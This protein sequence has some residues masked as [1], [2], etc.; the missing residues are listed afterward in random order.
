EK[1]KS[2]MTPSKDD[3]RVPF[4]VSA[5]VVESLAYDLILGHD[6]M[7]H[8]GLDIRYSDDPVKITG[9]R[10]KEEAPR[11]AWFSEHPVQAS[12][13]CMKAHYYTSSSSSSAR[14]AS[15]AMAG[16]EDY[17]NDSFDL[18][19]PEYLPAS[20][21]LKVQVTPLSDEQLREKNLP[22]MSDGIP[23]VPPSAT[24]PE[25]ELVPVESW[26]PP[27]FQDV[28]D[29]EGDPL[30]D[31][32]RFAV[33]DFGDTSIRLPDFC[34]DPSAE[35]RPVATLCEEFS[36]LFA[37]RPGYCEAAEHCIN[38]GASAPQ[39][40]RVRP[41]PH[42]WR[43]E[44]TGML[45]EM[46]SLGV[47]R[48]STSPWRYPCV[49]VPKK[50]GKVRMCIDYRGLNRLCETEAY[51]V[52]RPDDVQEHLG[53]AKYFTTLDL[54]SGYWQVP[55]RPED[56]A[57]TAFCPG[58]GFP[59]YEWLRMPFGLASAPATFQRLMDSIVGDL[60]FVKCYL[61][62]LLIYSSSMEEHLDHLRQVFAIL[63]K[64]GL[65]IAAEKCAI[66]ETTVDYLGH[67]FGPDGMMPDAKKVD[68]IL[69]WPTPT[70]VTELR[71]FLGLANY[72]RG[73][74]PHYSE[75]T[76]ALYDLLTGTAK[77]KLSA[78]PPW[79]PV[80]EVAFLDVKES[81][82]RLPLLAYP[83]F[84]RPFQLV[85]D[86]SDV[87]IGSVLE[88]D[89]RPLCFFSQ[90]LTATQKRWPVYEREAFAIFRSLDR[91]RNLLLG[92]HLELIVYTDHKPLTFMA[93]STTPKVQ[94]WMLSLC[95]Y[96]FTVKYRPGKENVVADA[97]SRIPSARTVT[98]EIDGDGEAMI[99]VGPA[100][101]L[102]PCGTSTVT[103]SPDVLRWSS[104]SYGT[105]DEGLVVI[106]LTLP[107]DV[108]LREQLADP[109]L[110]LLRRKLRPD[111]W[112]PEDYLNHRLVPYRFKLSSLGLD[113]RGLLVRRL[114][115][116]PEQ[117]ATY[118]PVMPARLRPQ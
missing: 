105:I 19:C 22:V 21:G 45:Q 60:P 63:R 99:P 16:R 52:P 117:G 64:F 81:L 85:T 43:E 49:F 113:T 91:F 96:E 97:L 8:F 14:S 40:E 112:L 20:A 88:Q 23:M 48:R 58:P 87:A 36:D 24:P 98:D 90:S 32:L 115:P 95:Q 83:D 29:L 101:M 94:R 33:P 37:V 73:F 9:D 26:P 104:L 55:V 67:T 56:Q 57:K 116:L 42:R 82:A 68:A 31:P 18:S 12:N 92:Y 46:E 78:L 61:D 103:Y 4:N 10:P 86:A 27:G 3:P 54:R 38:T 114:T 111:L 11:T 75:R 65:T 77:S 108:L 107:R 72:Y 28:D 80:H 76:R 93:T 110:A 79:T 59:L 102:M 6:F 17:A 2:G 70:T 25:D 89:G 39:C 15:V 41:L 74:L 109:D 51:P 66:A 1:A 84:S 47:I 13:L 30:A 100:A 71:S 62:D 50:N 7:S 53:N 69:R 118:V 34:D 5:L 44:V 106:P 35:R